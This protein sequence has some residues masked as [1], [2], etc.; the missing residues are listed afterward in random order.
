MEHLSRPEPKGRYLMM[1]SLTAIGV[2]YGDIGTSPLYAIRECFAGHS[3]LP[4]SLLNILGVL[5]LIFWSLVLV[6]SLKY[7]VFILRADNNGEGGILALTA[8]VS[9]MRASAIGGRWLLV[10]MGMFGA[11]LL[12][13]DGMITPAISVLSAVEGLSIATPFFDP[14]ILPIT[15]GIII[16]LFWFQHRG[17]EGIGRVFGPVTLV[18]F[19]VL[20]V[21]G[22]EQI[23]QQPEVLAAV[24]PWHALTFFLHNGWTGFLVL[25]AVFLVVTGGEALYADMGHFGSRPIRLAWFTV[26]L[27]ALLLNYFGQG[28]LLLRHPETVVNPF[29]YMAPKWAL[30]PLVAMATVATIIASQAVISGAFSLTMQAIQL[31]YSPRLDIEHTSSREFGQIYL[32]GINWGLMVA[33]ICLVIGFG[34]SGHLAA[35]YGVAVTSTMVITTVLFYFVAAHRWHWPKPIAALL[36]G[37]FMIFD[38]AFFGANI[39]KVSHGGWFPLLVAALVFTA[40]ATWKRGRQILAERLRGTSVPVTSFIPD[41]Q[42]FKPH[43]VPGTSVFMNG[44]PEGTPSALLHNLKHNKVLHE[45]L[46][47]LSVFTEDRP[48]VSKK[49]RVSLEKL[50]KG[51]YRLGIHYG[52]ME[53]PL[54]PGALKDVS[55]D[56]GLFDLNQTTFFL[57]RETLILTHKPGMTLWRKYLFFFMSRNARSATSFFGLPP[58][59]VVELGTQVE[60]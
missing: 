19:L 60:I 7:L 47:I 38:L 36:C 31:G 52:F 51:I 54:I 26:V 4:V 3:N 32:P 23:T 10:I 45:R 53:D 17:T 44:N 6:I 16:G 55:F 42:R 13:G 1:M 25:G 22:V 50:E 30:Y 35:A 48:R 28:A 20:S 43:P 59:R 21:L 27:P 11:A 14:Y 29:Y 34:S 2:V 41:I 49:D 9:P 46:I 56:D 37:S 5:S 33:C 24:N 57:G 18:W 12:Y 15:I 8:L 39:I 40:M 58:N